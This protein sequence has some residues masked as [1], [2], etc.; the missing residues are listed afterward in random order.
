MTASTPDAAAVPAPRRRRFSSVNPRYYRAFLSALFPGLG[1]MAARQYRRAALLGGPVLIGALALV[2]VFALSD[3]FV[4]ASRLLDTNV[5]LAFLGVQVV[6]LVL[7]LLSVLLALEPRQLRRTRAVVASVLL[8]AFV[9]VPQAYL[10]YATVVARDQLARIFAP[11]QQPSTW[12]PIAN[13]TPPPPDATDNPFAP[14]GTVAPWGTPNIQDDRVTMLLIG[15]DNGGDRTTMNTD[16]MIIASLDPN[17]KTVSLLS[18]PRDM[19]DVPLPDGRV[20][21]RKIN[22]LMSYARWHPSQFPGAPSAQSVLVAAL[23]TLTGVQI[24]YWAQVNLPGLVKVVDSVGGIDVNI[25]HAFC[26]P[27]YQE[28]GQRGFAVLPGRYHL[29][30]SQA[31]AY[32]RVRHPAGESDFTRAARQ[33]EVIVALRDRLV[34]GGFLNDPIGLL[35][36]LGSTISTNISPDTISQYAGLG[37][38]V[39]RSHI[40]SEVV[41]P[42]L[43]RSGYDSRGSIQLPDITGIRRLAKQM[44]PPAGTVPTGVTPMTDVP[45]TQAKNLPKISSCYAP[46]PGPVTPTPSPTMTPGASPT[47]SGEPSSEPS[48]EPTSTP[49]ASPTA[50]PVVTPTAAPTIEPAP[51]ATPTAKPG[52]PEQSPS[53]SG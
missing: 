8:V 36:S 11:A 12:I 28:W 49:A 9:V 27:Y 45:D 14:G 41:D 21:S 23:S 53:V 38:D 24:D 6:I 25:A 52:K 1:Q 33:E 10:G 20:Y 22:S 2:A 47:S 26:D 18:I 4:F 39:S 16:T 17:T 5:L 3:R 31:L 32:A 43:V 50:T 7:R 13:V 19:V 15:V 46:K 42:P 40:Y 37:H 44:F 29:N 34:G 35:E 30:G 48:T 51:T